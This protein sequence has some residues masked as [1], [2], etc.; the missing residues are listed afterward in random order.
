[1]AGRAGIGGARPLFLSTAVHP[2]DGCCLLSRER[3]TSVRRGEASREAH[4]GDILLYWLD[5]EIYMNIRN[6]ENHETFLKRVNLDIHP[7]CQNSFAGG[8]N[9][10]EGPSSLPLQSLPGT[11]F[12]DWLSCTRCEVCAELPI[13]SGLGSLSGAHPIQKS[14]HFISSFWKRSLF[15]DPNLLPQMTKSCSFSRHSVRIFTQRRY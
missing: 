13:L 5:T 12:L 3:R 10:R 2:V 8:K 4:C 1:M 15:S 11:L 7:S 14:V 6:R 9:L